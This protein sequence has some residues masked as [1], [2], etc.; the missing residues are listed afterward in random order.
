MV[1][2]QDIHTPGPSPPMRDFQDKHYMSAVASLYAGG[3]EATRAQAAQLQIQLFRQLFAHHM[4]RLNMRVSP[5]KYAAVLEAREDFERDR[6]D[7]DRELFE[8]G[9]PRAYCIEVDKLALKFQ[10]MWLTC[11]NRV[12]TPHSWPCLRKSAF[13]C[14]IR[15]SCALSIRNKVRPASAA[16]PF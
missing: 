14:A 10:S 5:S 13:R 7:A 6:L 1:T 3:T 15:K 4:R 16:N 2:I 11:L 9:A 8:Q 12:N